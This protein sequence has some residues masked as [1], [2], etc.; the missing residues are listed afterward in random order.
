ML[1]IGILLLIIGAVLLVLGYTAWPPGRPIGGI[2]AGIGLILVVLAYV[3]PALAT[4]PDY[5]ADAHPTL[6]APV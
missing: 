6:T 1:T 5:K 3:L 4:P 2:C